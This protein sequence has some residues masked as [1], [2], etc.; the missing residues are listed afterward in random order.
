MTRR[1]P[2]LER[3]Y[4]EHKPF[5]RL[6]IAIINLRTGE[7]INFEERCWVDTGFDGGIHVPNFRRSEV[8]MVGIDPRL[9]TLTLAGGVR[10]P[11]YACLAFIREIEDYEIPAPGIETELIIQGTQDYGLIGLEVLKNWIAK[12]D[13]PRET[14]S[15]YM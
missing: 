2:I 12:F 15:F 14:L 13:G 7:T 9:T 5:V 10:V 8:M 1:N 3:G 6:R 4:S 11:G